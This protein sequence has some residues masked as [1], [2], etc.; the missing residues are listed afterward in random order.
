[1]DI[2]PSLRTLP[3]ISY[4]RL[5]SSM[6]NTFVYLGPLRH[7]GSAPTVAFSILSELPT[8]KAPIAAPPMIN[9]S[10]GC[11]IAARCPPASVKPPNTEAST[12]T[13]PTITSIANPASH[14]FSGDVDAGYDAVVRTRPNRAAGMSN[15]RQ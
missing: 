4:K 10:T 7:D 3:R 13:Y 11:S 12:I 9:N 15:C 2:N 6:Y 5:I 8:T 1:M 14:L